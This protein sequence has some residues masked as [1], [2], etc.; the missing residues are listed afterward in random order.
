M[1]NVHGSTR[2]ESIDGFSGHADYLEMLAWLMAFNKPVSR[3]FLTHG[4]PE[5]SESLQGKIREEFNWPVTIPEEGHAYT[6]DF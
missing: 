1:C 3:V 2:D 4:E 5:A 6:I